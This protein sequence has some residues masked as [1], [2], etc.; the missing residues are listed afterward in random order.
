MAGLAVVKARAVP[1]SREL[2]AQC[3]DVL[4]S[5]DHRT[6]DAGADSYLWAPR[7]STRRFSFDQVDLEDRAHNAIVFSG[8]PI[9][10]DMKSTLAYCV[11]MRSGAD[12]PPSY[13]L[14][15]V[16][17]A[18]PGWAEERKL[19]NTTCAEAIQTLY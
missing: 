1:D 10:S 5:F 16:G 2:F 13:W 18:F 15:M 12:H 7:K 11:E 8:L 17:I 4:S 14:A 3:S 9:V 19:P 6:H